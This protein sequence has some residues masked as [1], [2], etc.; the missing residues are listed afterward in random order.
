MNS[1]CN[2]PIDSIRLVINWSMMNSY[3]RKCHQVDPLSIPYKAIRCGFMNWWPIDPSKHHET[4]GRRASCKRLP[5]QSCSQILGSNWGCLNL[6]GN[7]QISSGWWYTYPS[8]KYEFVSWD[9]EIPNIWKNKS[10]VPNHQ[11]VM[12]RIL[13]FQM[14]MLNFQTNTLARIDVFKGRRTLQ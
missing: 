3:L 12:V 13:I 6:M 8:E 11:P 7:K 14:N 2:V 4:R 1:P 9:N 10:H 5:C